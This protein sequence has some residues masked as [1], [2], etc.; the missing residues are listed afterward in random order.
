MCIASSAFQSDNFTAQRFIE[1]EAVLLL[2]H[3]LTWSFCIGLV[4][5]LLKAVSCCSWL[6][7]RQCFGFVVEPNKRPNRFASV[8]YWWDDCRIANVR[9]WTWNIT[10][11]RRKGKPFLLW[12]KSILTGKMQNLFGFLPAC[13]IWYSSVSME[14]TLISVWANLV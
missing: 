9:R 3:W 8:Q 10:I 13:R 7:Y 11:G 1:E 6:I 12:L 14:R 5:T 2:S 4:H